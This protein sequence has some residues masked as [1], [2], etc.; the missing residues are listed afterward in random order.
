MNGWI[1]VGTFCRT[2]S[3]PKSDHDTVGEECAYGWTGEPDE[4]ECDCE[5]FILGGHDVIPV[6]S[7]STIED[8]E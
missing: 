3:H 1:S 6:R 4:D 5:Q 7:D 8:P 2:C